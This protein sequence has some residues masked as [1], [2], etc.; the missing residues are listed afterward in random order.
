M[1]KHERKT[2]QEEKKRNEE[3]VRKELAV[4]EL[5]KEYVRPRK[6]PYFQS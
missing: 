3:I 4:T 1:L 5:N 6:K 2:L